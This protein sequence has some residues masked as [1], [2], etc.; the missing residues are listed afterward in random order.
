MTTSN[1]A[2]INVPIMAVPQ[3]TSLSL[4]HQFIVGGGGSTQAHVLISHP[5]RR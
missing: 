3:A 1:K 2:R 4:G 5:R